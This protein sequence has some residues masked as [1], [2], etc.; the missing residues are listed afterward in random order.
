MLGRPREPMVPIRY[1]LFLQKELSLPGMGE[2]P[3]KSLRE[4]F[5]INVLFSKG[6]SALLTVFDWVVPMHSATLPQYMESMTARY[7]AV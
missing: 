7:D 4:V 2:R 3:I 1:Y 6:I 5:N